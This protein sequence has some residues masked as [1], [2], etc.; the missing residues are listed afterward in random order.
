MRTSVPR[1][2]CLVM[3]VFSLAG[4][5][6]MEQVSPRR[7]RNFAGDPKKPTLVFVHGVYHDSWAFE[8]FKEP[9]LSNGY[10]CSLVDLRG[11]SVEP[12]TS[13]KSRIGYREYLEDVS[14]TLD[15]IEG[16]KVLI[17]H[18]LGGL[19][20]LSLSNRSDVLGH[21]LIFTPLPSA[22]R[23][24]Q[25]GLVAEF[26]MKSMQ[27]LA[28]GNAAALYHDTR[29]T[30]RYFF[31]GY[32][33][34]ARKSEAFARICNQHEPTQLFREIMR[35]EFKRLE[36]PVPSLIVLGSEDPTV[37]ADVGCQLQELT[38]GSIV[39]IPRAGHDI[40]LEESSDIASNKIREWLRRQNW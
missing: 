17:G 19:L 21:A 7:H 28:T 30:D 16:G 13:S 9:F 22:V 15:E 18:S 20:A 23:K 10:S 14:G 31:S 40:M 25:L 1:F 6:V 26:P 24:K 34:Q 4:C 36:P 2:I 3:A 39:T 38:G 27:F 11:H 37:T 35:L 12:R 5:S 33:S 8:S 32:T 29:F